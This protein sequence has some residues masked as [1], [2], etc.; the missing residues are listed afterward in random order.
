MPV[1]SYTAMEG[2]RG[3]SGT[4]VAETP[5]Q[6]RDAL[7]GRGL[8]IQRVVV[9]EE[10]RGG[11]TLPSLSAF[12]R[13]KHSGELV[14]FVRELSTLL[15][16]GIPLLEAIDTLEKQYGG[17]FREC[18]LMLRDR[19]A[20]GVGLAEA[21]REQPRVFDELCVSITEVGESAGTLESSLE[22]LAE[23]KER[24]AAL[25]GKVGTAVIYP[26]IV[27]TMAVAVSLFLMTF[28]VP[29]LLEGLLEAGRPIPW[30]TRVV[31]G[32]SD[33]LIG[34]WYLL[35]GAGALVA[36][37]IGAWVSTPS[38]KLA[39]HRMQLRIPIV[40]P[41]IRKQ[42]IGRIA[43][44]VSTLMR[45]GVVFL[46]AVQIAQKGTSNLVLRGALER[47]EKAITAGQD[48]SAAL[49]ETKAFPPMVVQVFAV[50]QQSGRLEEMLDRLAVD[51]DRQVSSST[52]RLTAVLEP[53]TI[54][55]LVVVVGVIAFATVLPIL[56]AADVM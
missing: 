7:R 54:L 25:K 39:W 26:A 34:Y 6:A 35:V 3:V 41:L 45:S 50:G 49:E 42:A 17:R 9:Q 2:E 23:F 47:C 27:L 16:V 28:V 52:Q 46:R 40:G 37:M 38:G 31:K 33:F 4:I 29:N 22:R 53:V 32:A 48:I 30:A 20:A 11:T 5:R 51:Y 1:F 8:T 24:A 10:E 56:E 18:I 43:I 55:F 14:S 44:V 12:R 36:G 19:V 13:Q 15:G 21:M